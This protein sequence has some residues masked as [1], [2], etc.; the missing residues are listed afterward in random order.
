MEATSDREI[1]DCFGVMAQLRPHVDAGCFVERVRRLQQGGYR[2]IA[3]KRAGRVRA[4]AGIRVSEMLAYG[5]YLYVDDLITDERQ[6]SRGYG[7]LLLDH[8][9]AIALAEGCEALHLDSGVHRARAHGFYFREGLHIPSYH[10][11]MALVGDE[12][13]SAAAPGVTDR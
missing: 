6:R 13:R 2:L 11:S 9:K 3:L 12:I 4:L 1:S 5:R 10:F 8:V 7:T